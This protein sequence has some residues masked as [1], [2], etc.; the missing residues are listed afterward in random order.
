M[1]KWE[2]TIN[3]VN[4]TKNS[5]KLSDLPKSVGYSYINY[6][7]AAGF[8]TR[9]ER[10]TYKKILEIPNITLKELKEYAYGSKQI[11]ILEREY[12]LKKIG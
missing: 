2:I 6:L 10:G 12:K 11:K 1:T 9:T 3:I 8:I 5:F 7:R 4:N